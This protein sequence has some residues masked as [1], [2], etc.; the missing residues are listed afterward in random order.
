[1]QHQ[2]HTNNF[3]TSSYAHMQKLAGQFSNSKKL[4]R[5]RGTK[6]NKDGRREEKTGADL[7]PPGSKTVTAPAPWCGDHRPP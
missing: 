1:M 5:Q 4:R 2:C 6:D 7:A 3:S